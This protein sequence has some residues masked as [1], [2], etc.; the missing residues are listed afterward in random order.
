VKS[1]CSSKG[2]G[3]FLSND[4]ITISKQGNRLA[5]KYIENV[6]LLQ[7]FKNRKFDLRIWILVVGGKNFRIYYN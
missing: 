4:S 5:Q 1:Q 6:L 2:A 7:G 3:M